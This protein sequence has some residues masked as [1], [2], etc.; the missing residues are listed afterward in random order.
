MACGS[1]GFVDLGWWVVAYGSVDCALLPVV[2]VSIG[3]WW[4]VDPWVVVMCWCDVPWVWL[5]GYNVGVVG[6]SRRGL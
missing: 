4:V 6:G 1:V 5:L 2:W 3:L